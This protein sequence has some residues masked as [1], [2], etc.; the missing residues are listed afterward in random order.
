METENNQG[1]PQ[2]KADLLN[3]IDYAWSALQATISGL[4]EEQMTH[5]DAGGWSI[6][7]NLAHLTDWEEFM[8]LCHLQGQPPHT[9]LQ[10]DES[11]F[12][13]L[14][15]DGENAI[16][17][18]RS[19]NRPVAD[20]LA[21]LQRAHAQVLADLEQ[22]SYAELMKPQYTDDPAAGPLMNRVVGNTYEHYQEH[23]ANIQKAL[24]AS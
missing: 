19:K 24:K 4:T 23:L 5:P 22:W 16:L 7:D 14:D 1:L 6:K 8:R 2:S 10:I 18:Q 9:V 15:E 20:V 21:D 3:R 13:Q 12:K 17:H 11:H